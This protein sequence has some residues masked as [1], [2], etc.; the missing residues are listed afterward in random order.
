L[1]G[2]A[3]RQFLQYLSS[4]PLRIKRGHAARARPV[5][6]SVLPPTNVLCAFRAVAEAGSGCSGIRWSRHQPPPRSRAHRCFG[7]CCTPARG[8]NPARLCSAQT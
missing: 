8:R 5:T 4:K 6:L 7:T 1:E 2:T 3:P